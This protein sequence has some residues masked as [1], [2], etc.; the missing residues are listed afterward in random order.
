MEKINFTYMEEI[1]QCVLANESGILYSD[2]PISDKTVAIVN[3]LITVR[4]NPTSPVNPT[5]TSNT[6][7]THREPAI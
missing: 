4:K 5:I 7:A 2:K 3:G 1:P 6:D